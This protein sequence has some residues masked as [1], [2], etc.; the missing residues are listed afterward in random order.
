MSEAVYD[1]F[2]WSVIKTESGLDCYCCKKIV[3]KARLFN[4]MQ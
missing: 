4:E 1:R 2:L 3:V